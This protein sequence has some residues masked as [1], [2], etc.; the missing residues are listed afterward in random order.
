MEKLIAT[1]L[2]VILLFGCIH[3]NGTVKEQS[4]PNE[5]IKNTTGNES[6]NIK[7]NSS[8]NV[9]PSNGSNNTG[10]VNVSG[11]ESNES[12]ETQDGEVE[13]WVNK[14]KSPLKVKLNGIEV[15][16][17]SIEE[18]DGNSRVT[19]VF[20]N[21]GEKFDVIEFRRGDVK[22]DDAGYELNI[23][24]HV[25]LNGSSEEVKLVKEGEVNNVFVNLEFFGG[26]PPYRTLVR[27]NTTFRP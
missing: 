7:E 9:S 22:I 19:L 20:K 27:M 8:Q 10:V 16:L 17:K 18:S 12:N 5:V 3:V 11:N 23:S 26:E 14:L 6:H 25:L 21:N 24:A 2:I 15:V 13:H 4:K 1:F